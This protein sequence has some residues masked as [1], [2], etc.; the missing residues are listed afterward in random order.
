M[1]NKIASGVYVR[2][3]GRLGHSTDGIGT[4]EPN[5]RSLVNW[6]P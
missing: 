1:I 4:P 3:D 2:A 6:C 5:P